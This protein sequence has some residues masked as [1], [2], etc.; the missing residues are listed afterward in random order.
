MVEQQ[1]TR[2]HLS[3]PLP[4]ILSQIFTATHIRPMHRRNFQDSSLMRQGRRLYA[5]WEP[6]R[7]I[8]IWSLLPTPQLLSSSSWN[9]SRTFLLPIS[10][11]RE[12][13]VDSDISITSIVTTV[14][15]GLERQRT[16]TITVFV[17]MLRWNNGCMG[18]QV[19][20]RAAS[21]GSLH[22]QAKAT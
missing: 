2:S 20:T 10:L 1:Y 21:W 7:N 12:T 8:L 3:T 22:I 5:S 4:R 13:K 6:T 16:T 9:P 17:M 18:K 14:L 11:L 19:R 15:S